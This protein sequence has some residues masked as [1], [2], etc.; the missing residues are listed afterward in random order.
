M[1]D[2]VRVLNSENQSQLT[3]SM[4]SNTD[5]VRVIDGNSFMS[6]NDTSMA[7]LQDDKHQMATALSMRAGKVIQDDASSDGGESNK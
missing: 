3:Q 5:I 2:I 6:G 1:G 4:R 7:S